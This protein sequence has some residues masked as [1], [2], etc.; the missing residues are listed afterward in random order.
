MREDMAKVIVERP[1][2]VDYRSR[3]GRDRPLDELPKQLGMRRSQ[4]ERGGYKNAQR[5]S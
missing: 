3:K 2:I 1:R 4:R 5:E